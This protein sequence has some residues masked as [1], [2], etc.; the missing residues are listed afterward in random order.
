MFRLDKAAI[1]T[2]VV[3]E[4]VDPKGD[5]HEQAQAVFSAM[6]NGKLEGGFPHPILAETYHAAAKLYRKLRVENPR[7]VASKL[8]EWLYRLPTAVVPGKN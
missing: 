8:V 7:A 5:L 6:L 1:D 2:S 3:I 4:Y